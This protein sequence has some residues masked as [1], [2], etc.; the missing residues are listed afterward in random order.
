MSLEFKKLGDGFWKKTRRAALIAATA[1]QVFSACSSWNESE[2]QDRYFVVQ[3][4]Q[5][6]TSI[7]KDSLGLSNE[8]REDWRLCYFITQSVIADNQF[9]NP[10]KIYPWDSIRVVPEH[11]QATIDE[12]KESERQ[13]QLIAEHEEE[14]LGTLW[15]TPDGW[16]D[17]LDTK[18]TG[19][20]TLK[21]WVVPASMQGSSLWDLY[22]A[23]L[24]A[25]YHK[26]T[27]K[28]DGIK[29]GEKR[30]WNKNQAIANLYYKKISRKNEKGFKVAKQ[31]Y[32]QTVSKIDFSD[33]HP[34]SLDQYKQNIS[35]IISDLRD[36]M[37]WNALWD[38]LFKWNKQKLNL[39][40]SIAGNIDENVLTSYSMTE[41]FPWEDKGEFNKDFLDF[42]L[43]NVG[44][45]YISYL[46]AVADD[47]TSFWQYQFTSLALYDTPQEKR[48]ASIINQF[49][50]ENLRIPWSVCKLKGKSHHR[51]AFLF[52]I[53]N[54][55][56]LIN[57][58]DDLTTKALNEIARKE[59]KADLTQLIAIMHNLPA[60]GKKYVDERYKLRHDK[61][62]FKKKTTLRGGKKYNYDLNRN[63][64][65][66]LYEV[67][68]SGNS[69]KY[70][71]KTYNN[72]HA[73]RK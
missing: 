12:Y 17:E 32:E 52:S 33:V 64:K 9:E 43:Q 71:K 35:K 25:P 27:R 57:K 26:D 69:H 39:L 54:I 15:E 10:D 4:W 65:I 67:F 16:D 6:I 50:P 72:Y 31:H 47:Y 73:I 55:S 49:V 58:N 45:E 24:W 18:P 37:D 14:D 42:L 38:K 51:A 30:S 48:G 34:I 61:K 2:Q 3:P 5:S 44:E 20:L 41:F 36:W 56:L 22:A 7:V 70:G 28:W 8:E 59:N 46:P 40:K 19:N 62:Y 11:V 13:K 29:L 21:W 63:G 53:Y 66:D 68:T 23:Y 60:N 1:A